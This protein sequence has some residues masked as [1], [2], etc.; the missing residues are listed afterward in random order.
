MNGK[1]KRSCLFCD[2]PSR[3][4]F[5][6]LSIE[7]EQVK[8]FY[9]LNKVLKVPQSQLDQCLREDHPDP[10]EWKI[11]ACQRCQGSLRHYFGSL[12]TI[13]EM[14]KRMAGIEEEFQAKIRMSG[15]GD[16]DWIRSMVYNHVANGNNCHKRKFSLFKGK[17]SSDWK[18]LMVSGIKTNGEKGRLGEEEEEDDVSECE[19]RFLRE[20]TR[21]GDE[22]NSTP[23]EPQVGLTPADLIGENEDEDEEKIQV[24]APKEDPL[25]D[26]GNNNHLHL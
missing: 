12:E 24:L 13:R 16:S 3:R 21:V 1:S 20:M 18:V 14:E 17:T 11:Q 15:G 7:K 9:I 25:D 4:Q 5:G 26:E 10:K 23:D 6:N 22:D 19:L 8:T 2:L